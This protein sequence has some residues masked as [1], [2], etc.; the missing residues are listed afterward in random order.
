[1][2]ASSIEGVR[3]EF[4][5]ASRSDLSAVVALLAD[6]ELGAERELASADLD[7]RYEQ[8][9]AEMCL[10]TGNELLIMLQG[11]KIVACLQLTLIPGLSRLGAKRAQI[12]GVRVARTHR[13]TGIG[14]RLMWNAL[15]RA[16]RAGC[17]LVQLTTD[18]KR[19][20]AQEFYLKLGF[21]P[22]HVGMK[23]VL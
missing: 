22:S 8:A 15:E 14:N 2:I 4:R 18:R 17:T 6:D 5:S 21:Q 10:Q 23:L 16:R 3:E 9:F 13:H 19:T 11:D 20:K 7:P 12:E 1:M